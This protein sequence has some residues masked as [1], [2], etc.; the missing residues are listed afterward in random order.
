MCPNLMKHLTLQGKGRG[1]GGEGGS[2]FDHRHQ[3]EGE[4]VMDRLKETIGQFPVK[5]LISKL[6]IEN[7]KVSFQYPCFVEMGRERK[8]MERNGIAM[9]RSNKFHT[10]PHLVTSSSKTHQPRGCISQQNSTL[11]RHIPNM[12]RLSVRCFIVLGTYLLP[13]NASRLHF[14][15]E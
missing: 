9:C 8:G 6:S 13:H 1:R 15:L 5:L 3:G 4:G 7:E 10:L 11:V 2:F 12:G 14:R